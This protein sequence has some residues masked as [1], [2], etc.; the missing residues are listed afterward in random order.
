MARV[1]ENVTLLLKDF[2][3]RLRDLRPLLLGPILDD[4]R[5]TEAL[6]FA[7]AGGFAGIAPWAPLSP[8]TLARKRGRSTRILVAS[9]KLERSL[10]VPGAS[11]SH[12]RM[13]GP[14]TLAF[15]TRVPYAEYH[16]LGTRSMPARPVLPRAWPPEDLDR[17]GRLT[18]D[19]VAGRGA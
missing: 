10:T 7:Q 16:Q 19:Y 11:G 6:L 8:R 18:A 3:G 17:W 12:V 14:A 15:G 9:G 2:K 13:I 4:L 5:A 1:V